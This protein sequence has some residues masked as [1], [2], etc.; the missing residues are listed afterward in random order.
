MYDQPKEK[1]KDD[2][3]SEE[4]REMNRRGT[5]MGERHDKSN[6]P[7]KVVIRMI[8]GGYAKGDSHRARKSQLRKAGG[9]HALGDECMDIG[10]V[11]NTTVI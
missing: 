5:R 11:T 9:M 10:V 4:D 7:R 2:P 1:C 3:N 8:L 6:F